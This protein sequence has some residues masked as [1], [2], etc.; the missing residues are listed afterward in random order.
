MQILRKKSVGGQKKPPLDPFFGHQTSI[1]SFLIFYHGWHCYLV[2]CWICV[3]NVAEFL[4]GK[5]GI[6]FLLLTSPGEFEPTASEFSLLFFD[7]WEWQAC[8][9]AIAVMYWGTIISITKQEFCS[10]W[11]CS[12]EF[13]NSSSHCQKHPELFFKTAQWALQN[14]LSECHFLT[15]RKKEKSSHN[16]AELDLNFWMFCYL[17]YQHIGLFLAHQMEDILLWKNCVRRYIYSPV[18]FTSA[19]SIFL[20]ENNFRS[21]QIVNHHVECK[22]AH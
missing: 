5:V 16:D 21:K 6:C 18:L 14:P 4:F 1:E 11:C 2:K 12:I 8:I 13:H 19:H 7:D 17:H 9:D 15:V 3:E 22:S 20:R 10:E